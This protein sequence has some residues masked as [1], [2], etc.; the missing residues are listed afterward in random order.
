VKDRPERHTADRR[1]GLPLSWSCSPGPNDVIFTVSQK[2]WVYRTPC[3]PEIKSLASTRSLCQ[4]YL[5]LR[6][7]PGR[8]TIAMSDCPNTCESRGDCQRAKSRLLM[9]VLVLACGWLAACSPPPL[10]HQ[11]RPRETLSA[12]GLRYGVSSHTLAHY[13]ALANPDKLEVGQWLRIPPPEQPR[14]ASV[15]TSRARAVS[16]AILE[17][18]PTLR[19]LLPDG[20]WPSDSPL[21]SWPVDGEV[22]SRFGPRNGK[23]HDGIDIAA[24]RGTPVFA[25]A[26][27]QVIFSDVLRGYGNVVIVRHAGGYLTLY[28]HNAVNQVQEGQRVRRGTRVATVGQSGHVTGAN[29]H[30]E[31]RRDNL[32]WDPLRYLPHDMHTVLRDPC[33]R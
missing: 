5:G 3:R 30:F 26:D 16:L 28:A 29:L 6:A 11:V 27:G 18:R 23:C 13:N 4:V 24:P 2:D 15:E 22:T 10:S 7:L 20:D 25:A 31:V 17:P 32:A 1:V 8:R 12:I 21:F 33:A 19:P 14:S 9:V